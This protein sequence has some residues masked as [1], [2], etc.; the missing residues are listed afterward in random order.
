MVGPGD[1]KWERLNKLPIFQTPP[2]VNSER[3]SQPVGMF[4]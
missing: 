4:H 1:G 3:L 2:G